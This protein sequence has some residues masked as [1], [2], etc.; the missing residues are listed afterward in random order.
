MEESTKGNLGVPDYADDDTS[1]NQ[2]D[3]KSKIIN[4][5]LLYFRSLS[6]V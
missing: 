5:I 3:S 2:S 4:N 1:L 6:C